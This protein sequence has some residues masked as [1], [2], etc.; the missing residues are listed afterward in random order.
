[1]LVFISGSRRLVLVNYLA[2]I[3]GAAGCLVTGPCLQRVLAS[4]GLSRTFLLLA[5]IFSV[6]FLV[7]FLYKPSAYR[8]E[9]QEMSD[10]TKKRNPLFDF[11]VLKHKPY[12]TFVIAT[13][14]L[15]V[16]F[17]A[18]YAHVVS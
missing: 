16:A 17:S 8:E 3:S 4:V 1:M 7:A 13:S 6:S 10:S 5:A 14:V 12:T 11:S 15:S 9:K 18:T 2:L